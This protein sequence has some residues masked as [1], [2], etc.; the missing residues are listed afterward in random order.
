VFG[1]GLAPDLRKVK[2]YRCD[3]TWVLHEDESKNDGA[4]WKCIS[5]YLKKNNLSGKS[6]YMLL[7]TSVY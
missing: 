3:G 6:T 1:L 5:C 7:G 2:C 4:F